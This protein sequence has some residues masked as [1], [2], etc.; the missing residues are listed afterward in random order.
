[1]ASAERSIAV[2]PAVVDRARPVQ[3]C[4]PEARGGGQPGVGFIDVLRRR[5]ALGPGERAVGLLA[6]L[7]VVARPHPFALD[8]ERHVGPQPDR[9]AGAGRVGRVTVAVDQRP[10]RRRAPVV[11]DGL[12]DQLD[13]DLPLEAQDGAHQHVVAVL[14]GG[15]PG[16][17]RDLVVV[18]AGA[19]RQRV[20]DHDPAGGRVPGRQRGCSSRARR[21]ARRRDVYPERPQ[22]EARRPGGRAACR[23]RSGSRSAARR[24][25]RSSRPAPPARRCGS[26]TGTRSR[27]SA[28]TARAPP[29]S[30][31]PCSSPV[32]TMPTHGSC[33][34]PCPATSS[35][36][37]S[38][39]HEPCA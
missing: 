5:E 24:A 38:G 6:L 7:E 22:P 4:P 18:I 10:L 35:S 9:L 25:S 1:M 26:S 37:A 34:L 32:L 23:T 20:A 16:V 2:A 33:H 28:G 11:E 14:V 15:W 3:P 19:H 8:A 36:A 27:R 12:A 17:G 31:A 30:G 21:Y 29:R 13:L 39:P